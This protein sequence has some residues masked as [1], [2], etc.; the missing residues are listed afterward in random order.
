MERNQPY[1]TKTLLVTV[2]TYPT[3]SA[4]YIET[5][6]VSGITDDRHWIRLHP[7][8]FRSLED[9]D[10]FPRYSRI[11]VRV[12]KSTRDTRPE[13]YHLDIDSI[14]QLGVIP[15]TNKWEQRRAVIEPLLSRSVEDLQD[16]NAAH[17]TSLGVIRPK[18]ITRFLVQETA[19]RWSPEQLAKLDQQELFALRQIPR[20]E[21]IPFRFAYE[22]KCDDPRCHGHNLQVFDWEV[23]QA[24]RNWRQGKTRTEWEQ[25]LRKEFDYKVRHMYDSLLFLGTLVAHP[26]NWIIGGI[27]FA[28]TERPV[29]TLW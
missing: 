15:T 12:N 24:Y 27:F 5:T 18:E 25:M 20:L 29:P 13:S 9:T 28:P 23:A 8:N 4:K 21:K 1:E 17:G 7:V 11:R 14:E 3:P 22:I 26:K 16:Q 19:P 6:C 10:K 2:K